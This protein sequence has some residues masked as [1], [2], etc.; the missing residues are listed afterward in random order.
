MEM[1]V[2]ASR[3]LYLASMERRKQQMIEMYL[4]KGNMAEI[5][6]VFGVTRERVRQIMVAAGVHQERKAMVDCAQDESGESLPSDLLSA[7]T[8]ATSV[9]PICI[10]DSTE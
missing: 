10:Q 6:R 7:A 4:A 8:P 9:D 2:I 5:G 3:E 1:D